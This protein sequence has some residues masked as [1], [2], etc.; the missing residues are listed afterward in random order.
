[1]K[2][3]ELEKVKEAISEI[4][5]AH[6]KRIGFGLLFRALQLEGIIMRD[7]NDTFSPRERKVIIQRF[8]LEDG[9]I[10]TLEE[11]AAMHGVTRERIRQIESKALRKYRR[12]IMDVWRRGKNGHRITDDHID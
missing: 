1:M 12:Y 5:Y 4:L 7:N 2:I 9:K 10:R 3:T 6:N 8:G 11:V